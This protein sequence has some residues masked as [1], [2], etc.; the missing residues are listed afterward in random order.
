MRVV[1]GIC[2]AQIV[3]FAIAAFNYFLKPAHGSIVTAGVVGKRAHFIVR[4]L[5]AV[6]AE[7]QHYTVIV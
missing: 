2:S 1:V 5:F 4:F 7:H 3:V 6:K